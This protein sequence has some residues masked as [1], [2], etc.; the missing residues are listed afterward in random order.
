MANCSKCV[1]GT[2]S[3]AN[4]ISCQIC[5]KG[6]VQPLALQDQCNACSPGTYQEL[7]GASKC[8]DCPAGWAAS[9]AESSQCG[10]CVEGRFGAS[11]K[12]VTCMRCPIGWA[13]GIAESSGCNLCTAG[14][15]QGVL[16]GTSCLDCQ[17]GFFSVTDESPTCKACPGGFY[18]PLGVQKECHACEQG[19]FS[20]LASRVCV[21][22]PDSVDVAPPR[23]VQAEVVFAR[24]SVV[25]GVPLS[26]DTPANARAM[27]FTLEEPAPG[28]G[29]Q[30]QFKGLTIMPI[31][32]VVWW[33]QREDFTDSKEV[34]RFTASGW[35]NETEILVR[36]S[37]TVERYRQLEVELP[38]S[39][40]TQGFSLR[41]RAASYLNDTSWTRVATTATLPCPELLGDGTTNLPCPPFIAD[42]GSSPE[43][44]ILH[45][46]Y[47]VPTS[48]P[49]RE[50]YES[51]LFRRGVPTLGSIR[52]TIQ[53]PTYRAIA[54]ND[55]LLE[56]MNLRSPR[57]K[58]LFAQVEWSPDANFARLFVGGRPECTVPGTK[59]ST[60]I[61]NFA[62]NLDSLS[63]SIFSYPKSKALL[64]F[65]VRAYLDDSSMTSVTN[66]TLRFPGMMIREP[67]NIGDE[68]FA[69]QI[70]NNSIVDDWTLTLRLMPPTLRN[71]ESHILF[72]EVQA[73]EKLQFR[74]LVDVMYSGDP[75]TP[76]CSRARNKSTVSDLAIANALK[77]L[78]G[79]INMFGDIDNKAESAHVPGCLVSDRVRIRVNPQ[80]SA[81][82]VVV[83]VTFPESIYEQGYFFRVSAVLS[84]SSVILQ[85]QT[86]DNWGASS[87]SCQFAKEY[88]QT[89]VESCNHLLFP[90]PIF[91]SLFFTPKKLSRWRRFSQ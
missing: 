36:A 46:E 1:A 31:Y 86:Y 5:A 62:A 34:G 42:A 9:S 48:G 51:S 76:A 69:P 11:N 79:E 15:A 84:D 43:P 85:D 56:S 27:R 75:E 26:R 22:I 6:T 60:T 24:E 45:G 17:P 80:N 59:I 49:E 13:S 28:V 2:W 40:Y 64:F 37:T 32:T 50:A 81:L 7:V 73:S 89:Y 90:P 66:P 53:L 20:E 82:P 52:V 44:S 38:T 63:N 68:D 30:G 33:A 54:Y 47:V 55:M 10:P 71:P 91:P 88:L 67:Q 70:L 3:L 35:D 25:D 29:S 18:Q 77:N 8:V 61:D 19:K 87:R 12:T 41:L 39:L 4:A 23:I 21:D 58:C 72:L 16:G 57:P 65:R 83:N 74:E 78:D 14:R